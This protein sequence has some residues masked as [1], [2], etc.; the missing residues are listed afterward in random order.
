MVERKSNLN[1]LPKNI[2]TLFNSGTIQGWSQHIYTM[3][4]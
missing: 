2:V 4:T 3:I 1:T